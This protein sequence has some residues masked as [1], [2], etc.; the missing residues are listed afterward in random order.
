[1]DKE[2]KI[3]QITYELETVGFKFLEPNVL[4][5]HTDILRFRVF[6][7]N[8]ID[9]A[10][11]TIKC[12]MDSNNAEKI[13]NEFLTLWIIEDAINKGYPRIKYESRGMVG[14]KSYE[15][16]SDVPKFLLSLSSEIIS[17]PVDETYP[18]LPS[19]SYLSDELKEIWN[20][21]KNYYE[22]REKLGSLANYCLTVLEKSDANKAK[23]LED[24]IE[25]RQAVRKIYGISKRILNKLGRLTNEA[26]GA[27]EGRKSQ[28]RDFTPSEKTWILAVLN[29]FLKQVQIRNNS[30]D[31]PDTLL[32]MEDLPQLKH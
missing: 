9:Y 6:Q 27:Q 13:A 21:Y 22:D 24:C 14:H 4:D 11:I 16:T 18:A 2:K 30:G 5:V 23:M 20:S 25:K 17:Q 3:W 32:S 12:L 1:M 7:K 26:G 8:N 15:D 10:V 19:T 28:Q 31:C 29:G